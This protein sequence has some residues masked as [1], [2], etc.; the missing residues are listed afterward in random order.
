[1]PYKSGSLLI[2]KNL[3]L[4]ALIILIF[5]FAVNVVAVDNL[6]S[7]ISAGIFHYMDGTVFVFFWIKNP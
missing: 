3:Y 7:V 4:S 6:Q 5:I 2:C 1:M